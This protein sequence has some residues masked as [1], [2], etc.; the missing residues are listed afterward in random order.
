MRRNYR[1]N[2]ANEID[3][4]GRITFAAR[5]GVVVGVSV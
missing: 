4:S 2:L 5:Y 3:M 1:G